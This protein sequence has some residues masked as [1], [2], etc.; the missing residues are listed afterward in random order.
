MAEQQAA[1]NLAGIDF[2]Q[3]RNWK[4]ITTP[5]GGVY[6]VVPGTPY[7]YDP[8]ASAA[9]GQTVLYLNPT[10]EIEDR[11]RQQDIQNAQMRSQS[12]EG[13]IIPV[14][15]GVAGTVGGAYAINQ[16]QNGSTPATPTAPTTPTVASPQPTVQQPAPTTT[17][18]TTPSQGFVQGAQ[19][20]AAV[21]TAGANTIPPGS[22][23]PEGYTAVGTSSSGGTIIAPT[24]QVE[25]LPPEALKDTGFLESVNWNQVGQGTMTALQAYSAYRSYQSGDYAGAAIYG[26]GAAATGA[27][28]LGSETAASVAPALG[29]VG[30][31]YQGYQVQQYQSDAA[32]GRQRDVNSTA[33]GAA[34]G[35]MIGS[36][37]PVVGTALGAVIGAAVGYAGSKFGSSKGKAQ[38]T[39]DIIRKGLKEN[40]VLDENWQGTL[41]DGSKYD[42]GKDGSTLKWKE[43]DKVASEN[44]AA[45]DGSIPLADAMAAGYGFVGQNASNVSAWYNKAAVSNAN[46]DPETAKANIRHFARQQGITYDMIKQKLDEAKAD[47]RIDEAQYNYYL[48]GAQ[49]L[50]EG[51]PAAPAP[52]Q[53]LA[54]VAPPPGTPPGAAPVAPPPGAPAPAPAPAPTLPPR[55]KTRSPGIDLQGRRVNYSN[56]GKQL[57]ERFNRRRR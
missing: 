26:S 56:M 1:P 30:G 53:K 51:Q 36:A 27:T 45:W 42:F 39:R 17:P 50:N 57:A 14:F 35:A 32:A 25:S 46:N 10:P 20:G 38:F 31:L 12:P 23:V 34:A 19:T 15:G 28:M 6:Y 7:V 48:G 37:I 13:Q 33:G 8:F 2:S 54:P 9:R 16:I 43:I 47:G 41:A 40:G 44:K 49:Q 21:P 4:Q 52:G 24:N 55:S 18:T 5:R 22:A 11:Q 3:Y 29:I